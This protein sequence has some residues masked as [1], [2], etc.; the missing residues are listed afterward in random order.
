MFKNK[1]K[2]S[3]RIIIYTALCLI[4]C[5]AVFYTEFMSA[6]AD[7]ESDCEF[8]DTI[9]DDCISEEIYDDDVL[10][11][12]EDIEVFENE[13]IEVFDDE[14]I[15]VFDD[16]EFPDPAPFYTVPG[17]APQ[18]GA[19]SDPNS[20]FV[21]LIHTH[22]GH[23]DTEGGCFTRV[24][25]HTHKG[26]KSK[27]GD[28]YQSPVYH[29]H[30]GSCYRTKSCTKN[31]SSIELISTHD[32]VCGDHGDTLSAQYR[33][34]YSHSSCG[35][36]SEDA[37]VTVS[38]TK[39]GG[40]HVY[41]KIKHDYNELKCSKNSK[42]VD[43]YSLTCKKTPGTTVDHYEP[44]CEL[45]EN[46]AY[47]KLI[48]TN[49][50]PDW[51]TDN[52]TMTGSL[53]D[54]SGI[55][56]H[57]GLGT[58][59][60]TTDDGHIEEMNSD[61]IIVSE[62]GTYTLSVSA[63]PDYFD[64]A[65]TSVM[66]KVSNI[67]RTAPT[68]SEINYDDS[69]V[70]LLSNT[71]TVAAS[72]L[73]PD[74]SYGSGLCGDAY[75][76]DGGKT[77]QSDN[78]YD[79]KENGAY[80]VWVK[81]N[82]G[83]I[84]YSDF[85]ISNIDNIGPSLTYSYSPDKWYSTSHSPRQFVFTA[86]DSGA[87]LSETAYSY[88]GGKSW[89]ALNITYRNTDG[90]FTV[91]A[92]DLLGNIHSEEINNSY[93]KSDSNSDDDKDDNNDSDDDDD[94]DDDDANDNEDNDAKD[95][96]DHND[97]NKEDK[98]HVDDNSNDDTHTSACD[99]DDNS[100]YSEYDVFPDEY[101]GDGPKLTLSEVSSSDEK[102]FVAPVN[103]SPAT[104]LPLSDKASN[105]TALLASP[106]FKV[107]AGGAGSLTCLAL[108]FLCFSLLY[109]GIR[110]YSF[111]GKKYRFHAIVP[112]RHTERGLTINISEELLELSFSSKY[113]LMPGPVFAKH[114][115]NELLHVN[116]NGTWK[117]ARIDKSIILG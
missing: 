27:G 104:L 18:T 26:S 100:N 92:R 101:Y 52:V 39:C 114:H 16:E 35:H 53:E 74:G 54:Y 96:D 24:I 7:D 31:P 55:L 109:S 6:N 50:T 102:T 89:T 22:R 57:D 13:I 112:V 29:K 86:K 108:L 110:V 23:N 70:W 46:T 65:C 33:V 10:V 76:F 98:Y 111:D 28:C 4:Y 75:S 67:D 79:F 36:K 21:E 71:V 91:M 49:T 56:T 59:S 11:C 103:L 45:D 17:R 58:L 51:T 66:L 106:A 95:S 117:H 63:D 61:N 44:G 19:S 72:D 32:T 60:F 62:N 30:S 68:I 83:N 48:L 43:S 25:Y 107:V 73:Q 37:T 82:C 41:N 34:T 87:G 40:S 5:I 116:L 80:T 12:D 14:S 93:S 90:T 38:C 99:N 105:I 69:E 77:W 94:D 8:P 2:Q 64:N 84:A 1:S 3:T 88:D 78:F 20:S 81:D 47:G 85:T 42:T 113:K 97:D 115:K 9:Y 15:E